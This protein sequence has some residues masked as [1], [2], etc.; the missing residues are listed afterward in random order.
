MVRRLTL[1]QR[2]SLAFAVLLVA[3]CGLSGW[4]QVRFNARHGEEAIQRLSLG[5]AG[6]IAGSATLMSTGGLNGPAV[7]ALFGKLMDVNPSVEVYLL[8]NE[9]QVLAHDAPPGHVRRTRVDLEPVRHYLQGDALPIEGDDPRSMG[10]RKVFSAAP[11]QVNGRQVGYVYVILMGETLDEV[12]G[13]VADAAA[14]RQRLWRMSLVVGAGLLAGLMAFRWITR[15]LRL[16]TQ[17]IEQFDA[18]GVSVVAPP[19][20]EGQGSRDEIQTLRL[21]FSRMTQRILSQWQELTRQDQQ[22]RELVANVSHDLRTPLTSL[23]GYLETLRLKAADLSEADRQR[24][25]DVA[26]A[27]SQKVGRLAQELFELARLEHG[28]VKPNREQF[29]LAELVQDVLQ[30]FELSAESRR[31]Q[32]GADIAPDLPPISADIGMIE[33]VLTNLLDNAVRHTPAE[34]RVEV[35]LRRAQGHIEVQVS[36]TG[37]GIPEAVQRDL[38]S[39]PAWHSQWRAGGGGLGLLI[40]QR[41]LNLH[42]GQIQLLQRGGHGVVWRFQLDVAG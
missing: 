36:D 40:V 26:L 29:S 22:R 1:S 6:Q 38:F 33:R 12:S 7:Q 9:G 30:K 16:L 23:H 8:D 35:R 21:A 4:L 19:Q 14:M 27:Q 34:G 42:G 5:L 11:L 31:L 24:Y 3:T 13:R 25:L 41:I 32:L 37:P 17:E 18:N 2:L 15:P 10:A 28:V 20:G 39:R